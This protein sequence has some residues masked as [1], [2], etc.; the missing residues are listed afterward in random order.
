MIDPMM[1]IDALKTT[2]L[3]YPPQPTTTSVAPIPTVVPDVPRFEK[4]TQT[5]TKTLWVV[6]VLMFLSTLLLAFQTWRLPTQKRLFHILTTFITAI[7]T[8]S[9]FAQA[10]GAGTT[11]A[12]HLVKSHHKH[13][14]P[15]TLQHVFRQVFWARYVDWAL[16][17]PLI[18]LD[19]AL[20]A[21]IDGFNI[22]VTLFADLVMVFTGWFFALA[23][24]KGQRWGWYA[25][26]CVAFLVV[27]HQ[28][29]IP[30]RRAVANKDK[31]VAG[32]FAFL[33][34]YTLVV[35]ALYPIVWAIGDGARKWSVDGEIIALAVVD[36]LAK[37]I[38]GFWLLIAYS[39]YIPSLDSFWTRGLSSEG[40][41]R[42]DDDAA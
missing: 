4:I 27:V 28:L 12:H 20:L 33:A 14:I 21:G 13:D 5:G 31:H 1:V 38:F 24:T 16:T 41:V 18:L 30:G 34:S 22:L 26:A 11:F 42:L 29:A 36:I 10:T 19:L 8:L 2:P 17:T 25:M 3:P 15:D 40:T 35:W 9:Y 39:K 37:P 7:A 32:I 6:F 23:Q